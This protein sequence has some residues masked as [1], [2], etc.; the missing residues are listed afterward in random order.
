MREQR[1]MNEQRDG[2]MPVVPERPKPT[3]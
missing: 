1:A 2:W 3:S